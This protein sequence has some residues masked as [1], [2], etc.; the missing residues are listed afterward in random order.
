MDAAKAVKM[1]KQKTIKK[2]DVK[3][4][5]KPQEAPNPTFR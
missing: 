4:D 1:R 2:K 5:S 3:K